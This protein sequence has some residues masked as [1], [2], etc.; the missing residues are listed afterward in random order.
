MP[1]GEVEGWTGADVGTA[2]WR[3]SW[4]GAFYGNSDVATLA[5]SAF[6]GTFG[7][8]D[9]ESTFAGSFGARRRLPAGA[10]ARTPPAV[11]LRGARGHLAA[12]Q[13]P[14]RR[15]IVPIPHN[16]GGGAAY[17][18]LPDGGGFPPPNAGG[19]QG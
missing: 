6:A 4:G 10:V 1:G 11:P 15:K 9:G 7:A 3:G 12:F 18:L 19:G 16:A 14:A 2:R 8:T 17:I 13:P 5:P